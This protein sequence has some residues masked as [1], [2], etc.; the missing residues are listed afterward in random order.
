MSWGSIVLLL[1]QMGFK[2][3]SYAQEHRLLKAGQDAAVAK[4]AMRVLDSTEQGKRLREQIAGLS[5]DE[6][7]AL[8]DDMKNA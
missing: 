3:L 6:A 1:L 8:W 2:L 4:M 7:D 5:E